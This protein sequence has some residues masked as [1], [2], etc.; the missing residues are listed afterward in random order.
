MRLRDRVALITGAA[1]GLGRTIA[2]VFAAEGARLVLADVAPDALDAAVRELGTG[3]AGCAGVRA[4]VSDPADAERIVAE[5][6]ARFG[7]LDCAINNAGVMDRMQMLDEAD[8]ELYR[9]VMAVNADGPFLVARAAVRQMLAQDPAGGCIVNIASLAGVGGM[10][11]G[12]AYTMSK[13]AVV[14]LTRSVA[15]AY[16]HRGVRCN[17]VLPG[18]MATSMGEGGTPDISA[19]G[20]RL[21]GEGF[22]Q[23]DTMIVV[24]TRQ[25]AATVAFLASDDARDVSGAEIAV[26]GGGASY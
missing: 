5:A 12:T 1:S 24:D 7:R 22:Q 13:H 19:Q 9:R 21:L 18:S 25:V 17:A 6:V 2:G 15:F 11:G 16:R 3:A 4:D 23:P 10:R 20:M 14:G 8:V 26:D